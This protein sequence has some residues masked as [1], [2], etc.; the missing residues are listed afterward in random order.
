L[1]G[2]LIGVMVMVFQWLDHKLVRR[3]TQL[4]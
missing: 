4:I 3:K 2:L 1:W